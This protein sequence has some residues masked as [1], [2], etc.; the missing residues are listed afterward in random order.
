[1]GSLGLADQLAWSKTGK[2]PIP[3]RPSHK[4]KVDGA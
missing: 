4:N 1:M 3:V 2:P